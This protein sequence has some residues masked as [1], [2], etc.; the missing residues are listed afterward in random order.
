MFEAAL[1]PFRGDMAKHQKLSMKKEAE[2]VCW[3]I[4]KGIYDFKWY[5]K[6]EFKDW[7]VDAPGE[8]FGIYLDEWKKQFQQRSSASQMN[9]FLTEHC[10]KWAERVLREVGSRK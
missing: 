8:Y 2:A 3:G 9:Q 7:A 10:P 5:S 4:L 1:E 6:T